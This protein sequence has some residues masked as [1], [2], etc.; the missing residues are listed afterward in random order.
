[1]NRFSLAYREQQQLFLFDRSYVAA[2]LLKVGGVSTLLARFVVQFFWNPAI[3]VTLTVCLL[4]LSSYL[5]WLFVR[6]SRKDWWSAVLCIVPSCI[7]GASISDGNLH[8]DYV[9]LIY[10]LQKVLW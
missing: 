6:E 5:L 1:M 10:K 7:M 4:T 8:Q 9:A 2:T 3:A